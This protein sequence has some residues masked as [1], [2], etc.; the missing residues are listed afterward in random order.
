MPWAC[1]GRRMTKPIPDGYHAITPYF[2]VEGAAEFIEFCKKA[3]GA[4][5]Q[6]R[7]PGPDGKIVHA[8]IVIGDSPVFVTDAIQDAPTSSATHL[9]V[10][11]VDAAWKR[12]TGAGAKGTQPPTDMPW[13][14]RYARFT[15]PW[16]NRW[17]MA[18]HVEDVSREEMRRRIEA[19][20]KK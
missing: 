9:Y 19:A 14:D 15:D 16:G 10:S 8:A 20:M 18:T 11:D 12:V 17:S 4:E 6:S 3:F 13:G 7:M 5:E 1:Y 2:C